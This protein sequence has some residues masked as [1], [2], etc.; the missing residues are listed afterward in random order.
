MVVL[1]PWWSLALVLVV[2]QDSSLAEHAGEYDFLYFPD[3]GHGHGEREEDE[4]DGEHCTA[5]PSAAH[6]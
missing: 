6:G 5:C 4:H 3:Q 2:R 1:G